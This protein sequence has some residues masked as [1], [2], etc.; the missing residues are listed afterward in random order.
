VPGFSP[1]DIDLDNDV[2]LTDALLALRFS[3]GMEASDLSSSIV[4]PWIVDVNDNNRLG[5]EDVIYIIRQL[6]ELR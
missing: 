6:A 4:L 3:A 1:G 5:L 2:D